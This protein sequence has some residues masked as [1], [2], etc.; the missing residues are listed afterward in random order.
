MD[1]LYDFGTHVRLELPYERYGIEKIVQLRPKLPPLNLAPPSQ[2]KY[3]WL[4]QQTEL[5][6]HTLLNT[7]GTLTNRTLVYDARHLSLTQR[8]RGYWG[9]EA[10]YRNAVQTDIHGDETCTGACGLSGDLNRSILLRCHPKGIEWM[11]VGAISTLPYT[12]RGKQWED[13]NLHD[14]TLVYD[15][16]N[17]VL[18]NS[19]ALSRT[20]VVVPKQDL[21][22]FEPLDVEKE[23]AD[24][25][26][27]MRT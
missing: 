23:K 2:E 7:I 11:R 3:Q 12:A 13:T 22:E 21:G 26:F 19:K 5:P 25:I 6:V 9:L 15:S 4:A 1:D 10:Y 14:V 16:T 17:W 8:L 24:E 20:Q 27:R 18:L